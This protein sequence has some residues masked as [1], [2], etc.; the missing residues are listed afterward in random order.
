MNNTDHTTPSAAQLQ[1][2]IDQI[3]QGFGYPETVS[4]TYTVDGDC[5]RTTI[6]VERPGTHT[7]TVYELVADGHADETDPVLH[8]QEQTG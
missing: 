8:E 6:T 3:V 7:A 5:K 1:E 4:I 2:A